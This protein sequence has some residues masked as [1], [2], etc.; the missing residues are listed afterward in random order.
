MGVIASTCMTGGPTTAEGR[1]PSS[2]AVPARCAVTPASEPG[3]G[4]WAWGWWG[5]LVPSVTRSCWETGERR[6]LLKKED[7]FLVACGQP[8][9][10]GGGGRLVV[11]MGVGG[12]LL[13][14]WGAH[15]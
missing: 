4:G 12:G 13:A 15:G 6:G 10:G 1:R 3:G 2:G 8:G 11:M 14:F 5:W 9:G 7:C